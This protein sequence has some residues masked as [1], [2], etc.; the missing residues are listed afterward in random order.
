MEIGAPARLVVR[1]LYNAQGRTSSTSSR[2]SRSS[3]PC[4]TSSTRR[5]SCRSGATT[6]P[7]KPPGRT[8]GGRRRLSGEARS[9]RYP[10]DPLCREVSALRGVSRSHGVGL[11][12]GARLLRLEPQLPRLLAEQAGLRDVDSGSRDGR[13]PFRIIACVTL[14]RSWNSWEPMPH[15]FSSSTP[16][17]VNH[18]PPPTG[19]LSAAGVSS[20]QEGRSNRKAGYGTR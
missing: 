2:R 12:A 10:R 17:P 9:R 11:A 18:P 16:R 13:D 5:A 1:A 8:R 3:S 7:E 20:G 4:A 14:A 15:P 19:R 6:P